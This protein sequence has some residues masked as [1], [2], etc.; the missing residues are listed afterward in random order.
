MKTKNE[1]LLEKFKADNSHIKDEKTLSIIESAL[2]W[3]D[4]HPT[5]EMLEKIFK[6]DENARKYWEDCVRAYADFNEN[7]IEFRMNYI[8]KYWN[9]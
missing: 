4:T 1:L 8:I 5:I 9:D 6:L 7:Y 3:F 2:N